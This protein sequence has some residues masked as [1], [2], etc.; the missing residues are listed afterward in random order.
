MSVSESEGEESSETQRTIPVLG[1]SRHVFDTLHA[2]PEEFLDGLDEAVRGPPC[3]LVERDE[4]VRVQFRSVGS[5]RLREGEGG[6]RPNVPEGNAIEC[7]ARR[8]DAREALDEERPER[9][10][11][12]MS[13][14]SG[15]EFGL[16]LEIICGDA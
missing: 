4:R 9:G 13:R 16:R 5:T 7:V 6:T 1:Q 14:T 11:G 10:N 15:V 3:E 12:N 2:P 8:P